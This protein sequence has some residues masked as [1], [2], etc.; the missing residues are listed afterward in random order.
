MVETYLMR[1]PSAAPRG[2]F[3][4]SKSSHLIRNGVFDW[5]IP[6]SISFVHFRRALRIGQ[7]YLLRLILVCPLDDIYFQK[8]FL[9]VRELEPSSALELEGRATQHPGRMYEDA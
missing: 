8:W 4:K 3:S 7:I 5:V 6:R 1:W 2:C 9:L